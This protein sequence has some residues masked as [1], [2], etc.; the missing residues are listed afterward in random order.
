MVLSRGVRGNVRIISIE[1][2]LNQCWNASLRIQHS[3]TR[4]Q[5]TQITFLSRFLY[6]CESTA[7]TQTTVPTYINISLHAILERQLI[8]FVPPVVIITP[9]PPPSHPSSTLPN[10][11][12]VC[13]KARR[14]AVIVYGSPSTFLPASALPPSF[15]LSGG[16]P[17][18]HFEHFLSCMPPIFDTTE[19]W[20]SERNRSR[21]A[22]NYNRNPEPKFRVH[23][24]PSLSGQGREDY[25][26]H[27]YLYETKSALHALRF[28]RLRPLLLRSSKTN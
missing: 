15:L 14:T 11:A 22:Y 8:Y 1:L 28:Q 17:K 2:K 20:N 27:R 6:R 21:K 23:V 12:S 5:T 16:G 7:F 26:R 18:A 25:G 3:R 19:W 10:A 9:L 24:F 4:H 13:L